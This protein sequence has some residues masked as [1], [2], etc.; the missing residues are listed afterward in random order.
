MNHQSYASPQNP[1]ITHDAES[2][3]DVLALLF[4]VAAKYKIDMLIKVINAHGVFRDLVLPDLLDSNR[5]VLHF[6][7][8]KLLCNKTAIAVFTTH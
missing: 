8:R 3:T 1:I 6:L 4:E 5:T 7:M 2:M